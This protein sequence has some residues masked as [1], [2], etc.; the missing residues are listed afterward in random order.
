MSKKSYTIDRRRF[1]AGAAGTAVIASGLGGFP[2][3]AKAAA[4]IKIGVISPVTGFL[5]LKLARGKSR[6]AEVHGWLGVW[7]ALAA[8]L[9]AFAGFVLLP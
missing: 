1:V 9:A 5:G 2:H 4:P 7:A 6:A 8:G 3:I